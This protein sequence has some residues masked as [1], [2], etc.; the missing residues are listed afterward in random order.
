MK[1]IVTL[2]KVLEKKVVVEA[3]DST[4]V[5][6]KLIAN[7]IVGEFE[8]TIS[9][10]SYHGW[11]YQSRVVGGIDQ[12]CLPVDDSDTVICDLEDFAK[13][14]GCDDSGQLKRVLFRATEC[15]MNY[16]ATED[17]LIL[18]GYVEGADCDHPSERLMYPFTGSYVRKVIARL[19]E[20]ADEMW[21]EWND[22]EEDD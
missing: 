17:S 9:S 3:M 11:D 22:S 2:R 14:L 8:R 12:N 15:G 5:D 20:E 4:E 6:H 13:W 1:Y 21:H 10:D 18:I 19:E 16:E 7:D